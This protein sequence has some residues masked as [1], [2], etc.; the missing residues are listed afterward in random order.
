MRKGR[1]GPRMRC[2]AGG[3]ALSAWPR[4]DSRG[5]GWLAAGRRDLRGILG[6]LVGHEGARAAPRHHVAF[7]KSSASASCV[8]VRDTP[9]SAASARDEPMRARGPRMRLR[10]A[11]LSARR[12]VRAG[13]HDRVGPVHRKDGRRSPGHLPA[14]LTSR[15]APRPSRPAVVSRA[16]PV[17]A[18]WGLRSAVSRA[19]CLP[20]GLGLSFHQGAC[21]APCH[22][23]TEGH[24]GGQP[25]AIDT[26]PSACAGSTRADP[27]ARR[28]R[29]DAVA[30]S[31]AS[32]YPPS[33]A[34]GRRCTAFS[35][36]RC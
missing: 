5:D 3:P 11:S 7:G 14:S 35:T 16:G 12:S 4:R 15:R 31:A 26:W 25:A 19:H 36:R 20:A 13:R 1:A 24:S 34:P 33:A 2:A 28:L 30:R 29:R 18:G 27:R 32:G 17:G 22:R 9:S 8:V 23:R 10:I 21:R 6:K